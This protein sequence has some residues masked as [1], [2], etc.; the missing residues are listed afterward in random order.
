MSQAPMSCVIRVA[1]SGR[2]HVPRALSGNRNVPDVSPGIAVPVR[3]HAGSGHRNT[4]AVAML[5]PRRVVRNR[6]DGMIDADRY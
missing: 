6:P 3:G 2:G 4:L 5:S 1:G